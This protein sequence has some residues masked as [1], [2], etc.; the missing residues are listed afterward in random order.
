MRDF[1]WRMGL[2]IVVLLA[3]CAFTPLPNLA[4]Q[5]LVVAARLEPAQ[6]IVVLGAGVEDRKT[7]SLGSLKRTVHGIQLYR[8]GW[9]PIIVFS[10]GLAGQEAPEATVMAQLAIDLGVPRDVIWTEARSN[11]T[12]TE[13]LEVARLM[14]P[15]GVRRI[16]LVTHPLHMRR[17]LTDFERAGFD[18]VPAGWEVAP[19]KNVKP[20]GR[21]SL[22]RDVGQELLAEIYY[23]VRATR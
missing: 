9:A 14:Q 1:G 13:A 20:E 23:R 19:G 12:R 5:W 16:L 8:Q 4:A 22:M 6:A 17:A 2:A 3:A 10:G 21:L 18:V 15:H 7:L 11:D